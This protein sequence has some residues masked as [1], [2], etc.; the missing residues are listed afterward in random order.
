MSSTVSELRAQITAMEEAHLA[1]LKLL[2]EAV[3]H[4]RD[5]KNFCRDG[6]DRFLESAGLPAISDGE[7]IALPGGSYD[8][9]NFTAS[10]LRKILGKRQA[11]FGAQLQ[12]IREEAIQAQIDEN[13]KISIGELNAVL[14]LLGLEQYVPQYTHRVVMEFG[15][16][17]TTDW[18]HTGEIQDMLDTAVADAVSALGGT[19]FEKEYTGVETEEKEE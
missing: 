17:S 8:L 9:A 12:N 6:V 1:K 19:E 7:K 5:E 15:F 18:D 14:Q 2:R 11:E 10:G 3:L 13:G 4:M 16:T